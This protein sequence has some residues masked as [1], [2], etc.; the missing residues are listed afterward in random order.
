M[1]S[2][3][4]EG[5]LIG[6]SD[7]W[8]K[9]FGYTAEEVLG[10][11]SVDFL[12]PES[13]QYAREHVLPEFFR[14]GSIVDIPYQFIAKDG[15]VF[16]VLLSATSERDADGQVVRS[17]AVMTDVTERKH[18][19][20]SLLEAKRYAENLIQTANVMI[21]E[22]DATGCVHHMNRAA[23]LITG[24]PLDEIRGTS[25]FERIVP[26]EHYPQVWQEFESIIASGG[27][28]DEF[29]NLILTKDGE[30]RHIAWRNSQIV[31][32]NQVVG[33]LSFGLDMTEQKRMH[34]R[35]VFSESSLLE[36]QS[37]AHIGNWAYDLVTRELFWSNEVFNIL[38][39]DPATPPSSQSFMER[40][41]PEDREQ[42]KL[43]YHLF[44]SQH[45]PYEVT[46]R[47]QLPDGTLKYVSQH[48]RVVFDEHGAPLRLVGTLQ[49]V[50]L[51]ALQDIALKESED[52]F[53]TIADY[54]YDWEYWQGNQWEILHI[55][56]S[57]ERITGYKPT[58]FI[59][60]P[61]LMVDIIHPEDRDAYLTHKRDITGKP[62][63]DMVY[64]IVTK[65]GE[66][67]WIAHGC[68][69]VFSHDGTP[70][71][72]RG[73]N[74]DIT[75]L[76]EA[77]QLAHQLAYFDSLT[78][79][80]NRRMLMD[81]LLHALAQAK[82]FQ[83]AL[84]I[85]FL[86]LDRFKQV[87]DTL[88]HDTGDKLLVEVAGRL[89][90]S[91]RQGDTVARTG[92]DEFIII[93]PEIAHPS[94]ATKVAEKIIEAVD[95]PIDINGHTL[96]TSPSIGIAVYPINGTDDAEELMKKA[97]IAMYEAKQAGRNRYRM[98]SL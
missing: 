78:N 90:R 60:N 79:L 21:V 65:T 87:N 72:R 91:V 16:D 36:A 26:K 22:L 4:A 81:R 92:G 45:R 5:R 19:E 83:R 11:K 40:V 37:I 43:S 42:I 50:T 73:S 82:R 39:I 84:A 44:R 12:A 59:C 18:A 3:D 97:D 76:K 95:Q 28:V 38:E 24:Y 55:S 67:R 52:R 48:S 70:C 75:A 34:D 27:Q 9:T 58:E 23:E 6:V 66:I 47:L 17:L 71:G 93:L 1:H 31:R 7:H 74:R 33:S 56:P 8:L 69:A 41:H 14:S 49:D 64:R 15:R 35:L 25:W 77:E 46:C 20:Q 68:R 53:R 96:H 62:H 51:Q 54:T 98:F 88:G 85:M 10:R 57:C 94:D 32:N 13:Q 2:I 80:P 30:E 61:G 89:I 29:E 86:D 63:G